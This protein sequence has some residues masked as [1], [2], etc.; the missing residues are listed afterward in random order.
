MPQSSQSRR[1]PGNRKPADDVPPPTLSDLL[2]ELWAVLR[3]RMPARVPVPVRQRPA[4]PRRN[5]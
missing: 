3:P 4:Y 5:R 1:K 2:E